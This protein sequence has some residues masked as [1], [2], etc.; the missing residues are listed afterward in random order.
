MLSTIV[1]QP[2]NL[3]QWENDENL[4]ETKNQ[5]HFV[6]FV[7]VLVLVFNLTFGKFNGMCEW[8]CFKNCGT[9]KYVEKDQQQITTLKLKLDQLFRF[10][11]EWAKQAMKTK[12]RCKN[13]KEQLKMMCTISNNDKSKKRK[14]KKPINEERK[15]RGKKFACEK[16]DKLFLSIAKM[17]RKIKRQKNHQLEKRNRYIRF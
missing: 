8:F 14:K 2:V 7:V 9:R 15:T 16:Y 5:N 12:T 3:K 13:A 1:H 10:S 6:E 4:F 11:D 17:K